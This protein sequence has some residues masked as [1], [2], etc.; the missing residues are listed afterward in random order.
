MD[1]RLGL[2]GR[3]YWGNTYASELK[4]LGI[5]FWQAGRDWPEVLVN[6]PTDGVIVASSTDS[7]YRI[8]KTLLRFGVPVLVEK[9]VTLCARQALE[10]AGMG[11]IGFVGHTRLYSPAWRD[12]KASLGP[13][14]TVEAWAGGVN[15]TNPDAIW[16]WGSHLAAMCLDIG[17][18]PRKAVFHITEEKQALRF[19]ANGLEFVD[20]PPGALA[21]LITQFCEAIAKGAPDNRGMRLG[22]EVVKFTEELKHVVG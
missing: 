10:L 15:D 8:A 18:C 7:H 21:N 20:G 16:N 6:N 2:V 4:K 14:E 1:V 19:V 13:V 3:G 17:F 5:A 12:F 11:G 22:Y 9:P